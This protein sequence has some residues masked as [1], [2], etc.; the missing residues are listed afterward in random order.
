MTGEQKLIDHQRYCLSSDLILVL[1]LPTIHFK[2][3]ER[4]QPVRFV[5]YA[6]FECA[7]EP[8]TNS[9]ESITHNHIPHSY[10]FLVKDSSNDTQAIQRYRGPNAGQ[11]F[12]D[13]LKT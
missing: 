1:K 6:D 5:I 9:S 11:H 4:S 12:V 7:L 13:S 3:S 10:C 8:T 2:N